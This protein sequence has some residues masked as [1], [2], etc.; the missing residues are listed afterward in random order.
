MESAR[1]KR[2]DRVRCCWEFPAIVQ[3]FTIWRRYLK[4]VG[5]FSIVCETVELALLNENDLL[6]A[7]LHVKLLRAILEREDITYNREIER[8]QSATVWEDVLLDVVRDHDP[9][10]PLLESMGP[11]QQEP[12]DINLEV[13]RDFH[14]G[15]LD[16][17]QR[18]RLLYLLCELVLK[19]NHNLVN[20]VRDT[21][22]DPDDL[23]ANIVGVDSKNNTFYYMGDDRL[24]AE[25]V[26]SPAKIAKQ[27]NSK[28]KKAKAA[29]VA[30]A[31]EKRQAEIKIN[32]KQTAKRRRTINSAMTEI[33]TCEGRPYE[34]L[35]NHADDTVENNG[36]QQDE[37]QEY[38]PYELNQKLFY[39][40]TI[41]V[42]SEDWKN[43]G[44]TLSKS[45]FKIDKEIYD[46]LEV[47]I[48]TIVPKLEAREQE[49]EKQKVL[50]AIPRRTSTR[51]KRIERMTEEDKRRWFLKEEEERLRALA[52]E[53]KAL[54][55]KRKTEACEAK[56]ERE[57]KA[58]N[59]KLEA[60]RKRRVAQLEKQRRVQEREM[61]L[62]E[63]E[64][65][66]VQEREEEEALA[67]ERQE[68]LLLRTMTAEEKEQ[69]LTSKSG[70]SMKSGKEKKVST[71]SSKTSRVRKSRKAP[72]PVTAKTG[73]MGVMGK[74]KKTIPIPATKR[75]KSV[76]LVFNSAFANEA[77]KAV[78]RGDFNDIGEYHQNHQKECKKKMAPFETKKS[79]KER[80]QPKARTP[81]KSRIVKPELK[82]PT[83]ASAENDQKPGGI[84]SAYTV[85]PYAQVL[86]SALGGHS[87]G[88]DVL[89][90]AAANCDLT[91]K[92]TE[93]KNCNSKFSNMEATEIVLPE[94]VAQTAPSSSLAPCEQPSLEHTHVLSSSSGP[95]SKDC[96]DQSTTY[97][98]N[99]HF[100]R[101]STN[102]MRATDRIDT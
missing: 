21:D 72:I 41:C 25:S 64:Q 75:A 71:L 36:L 87:M 84:L 85:Q 101:V 89:L 58:K 23:R 30:K 98:S 1:Q 34:Q 33:N 17:V 29:S 46:Y 86:P 32:P 73:N 19:V 20:Y 100:D 7:E 53:K 43:L 65:V 83:T 97:S 99:L 63:R 52:E 82:S 66:L 35:P 18:V 31:T 96:A 50:D 2:L 27:K 102:M 56:K 6:L 11:K 42:T 91:V 67:A 92:A 81:A 13:S 69:Y 39:W 49:A 44:S 48:E 4:I 55:K 37:E 54:E 57:L 9:E 94:S 14:Y 76:F 60:D 38:F 26:Y 45:R 78:L 51:V 16:V 90:L 61:R 15:D 93:H 68:R 12:N 59:E 77:T 95:S 47:L 5:S 40:R 79:G 28:F 10:N 88:A 24:Y 8:G 80:A 74:D 3:F 70:A 22:V 62:K